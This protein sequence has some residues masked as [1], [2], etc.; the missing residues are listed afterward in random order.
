MQ[1]EPDGIN[2]ALAGTLRVALT[3]AGQV[4]EQ[5]ARAR[6][7]ALRRAQGESEQQARQLQARLEA[8]RS[9]ARAALAPV[10]REQW[11]KT[12]AAEDIAR[13]W[14]TAQAWQHVDPTA[15]QASERIHDELRGRFAIDTRDLRADPAAVRAA[16]AARSAATAGAGAERARGRDEEAEAAVLLAGA[17][18]ADAAQAAAAAARRGSALATDHLV[19]AAGRDELADAL[20]GVADG[21]TIQARVLATA[22][23][24]RPAAEAVT[25]TPRRAPRSAPFARRRCSEGPRPVA[26]A[27]WRPID[28]ASYLFCCGGNL[29]RGRELEPEAARLPRWRA[30]AAAGWNDAGEPAGR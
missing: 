12:A 23:Q 13:A 4:A 7:Q 1:H 24:A 20:E 30:A 22:N 21:E 25:V 5:L 9:A 3:V 27:R 14:E 16:L 29:L 11:W 8:E 17:S 6:E 10:A 19:E 15:R 28:L 18:R 2:E 26:L